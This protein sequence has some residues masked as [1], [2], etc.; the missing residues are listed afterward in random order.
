MN[1]RT[2]RIVHGALVGLIALGA[3]PANSVFA[4][5]GNSSSRM[6]FHPPPA[7]RWKPTTRSC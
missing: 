1:R 2:M 4:A 6:P 3:V 7:G 5:G